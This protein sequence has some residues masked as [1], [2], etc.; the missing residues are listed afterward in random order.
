MAA[1][2]FL[3][4]DGVINQEKSGSYIFHPDEFIFYEHAKDALVQF[5]KHF[6]Y[7]IIVTNQRG[8]G[9]GFMTAKAL[10]SIHDHLKNEVEQA[11][12]KID[13]IYYAPNIEDTDPFRKPNIGMGLKA[14]EDFPDIDFEKSVMVGNNLSDMQFGRSLGM[15]TIFLHTTQASFSHL[16]KLI[17][18]QFDSLW[19]YWLHWNRQP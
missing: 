7:L 3:D 11:G 9:R 19:S 4:R 5:S 6:D 18:Q 13:A 2:L 10:H 1:A 12:G 14:K 16:P 8:I 15:E 17:D